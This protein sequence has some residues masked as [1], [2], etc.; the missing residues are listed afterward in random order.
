MSKSFLEGLVV[1]A[2]L[3]E[4]FIFDTSVGRRDRIRGQ[5]KPA[6]DR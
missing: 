2:A 6:D 4:S 5:R 1:V 3:A